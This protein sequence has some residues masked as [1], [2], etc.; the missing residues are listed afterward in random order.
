MKEREREKQTDTQRDRYTER[1]T[2]RYLNKQRNRNTEIKKIEKQAH[3]D[4]Q[5]DR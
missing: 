4:R 2:Y 5:I 3:T 1:Q